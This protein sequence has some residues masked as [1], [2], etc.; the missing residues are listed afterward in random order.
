M[1][2]PA[3]FPLLPATPTPPPQAVPTTHGTAGPT[4]NAFLGFGLLRPFRRDGKSDFAHDDGIALVRACVGQLL[5][6]RCSS[7]YTQGEIPWRTEFGSL[8]YLLRHQQNNAV[9]GE[10]A[11]VYIADALKRWEPRVVLRSVV[12]TRESTPDGQGNVLALRIRY[13]VIQANV[14]GNQ[15]LIPNV[16]QVV[17]VPQ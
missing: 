7:E 12:A 13:D 6:T 17:Q 5:G 4:S 14:A 10:L 11:R 15:V 8:L 1:P 2:T 16:E 3:R 9:L